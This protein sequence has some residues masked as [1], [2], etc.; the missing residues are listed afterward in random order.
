MTNYIKP[1]MDCRHVVL[2]YDAKGKEL[3]GKGWCVNLDSHVSVISQRFESFGD[4]QMFITDN[5]WWFLPSFNEE[6]KQ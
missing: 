5:T 1:K 4:A 3:D 2:Y 6:V